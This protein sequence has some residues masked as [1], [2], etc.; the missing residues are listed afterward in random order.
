MITFFPCFDDECLISTLSRPTIMLKPCFK[1]DQQLIE[2][3]IHH[4]SILWSVYRKKESVCNIFLCPIKC[5][6]FTIGFKFYR[7]LSCD[8]QLIVA[9]YIDHMNLIL[10]QAWSISNFLNWNY[11]E[12]R[13][14]DLGS[15]WTSL[16]LCLESILTCE[17]SVIGEQMLNPGV[18]LNPGPE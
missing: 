13:R 9:C 12:E 1:F 18:V 2:N 8:F 11:E 6:I 16:Q 15:L 17:M 4:G 5:I 14:T 10:L 3:S 7:T